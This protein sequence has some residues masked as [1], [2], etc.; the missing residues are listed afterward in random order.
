MAPD[1]R[2]VERVGHPFCSIHSHHQR[3]SE[4]RSLGDGDGV[5]FVPINACLLQRLLDHGNNG[6]HMAAG[7]KLRYNA[8]VALME[9]EL[10]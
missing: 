9:V 10:G 7:G 3:T 8:A 5:D 4:P 6:C 2:S 1:E